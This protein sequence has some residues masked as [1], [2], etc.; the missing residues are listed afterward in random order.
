M[1]LRGAVAGGLAVLLLPLMLA[2][3]RVRNRRRNAAMA[4][5]WATFRRS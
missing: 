3:A 2:A 5:W 4:E 1:N